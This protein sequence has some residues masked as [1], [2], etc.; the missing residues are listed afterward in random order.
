MPMPKLFTDRKSILLNL[1]ADD[2]ALIEAE[3]GR[4]DPPMKR[5]KLIRE[6]LLEALAARETA[7]A[8]APTDQGTD[9]AAEVLAIVDATDPQHRGDCD[10]GVLRAALAGVPRAELDATLLQLERD[11]IVDLNVAQ[12]PTDRQRRDGIVR[13]GRGV[14]FWV[15]RR[16]DTKAAAKG[17]R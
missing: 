13:E 14:V 11:W 12:A 3:M 16:S 15:C 9:L 6:L 10:L 2:M 4:T 5:V 8:A 17:G 7:R 1:E